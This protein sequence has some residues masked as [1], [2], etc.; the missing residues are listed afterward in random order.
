MK[1]TLLQPLL[2]PSRRAVS[3][4][5]YGTLSFLLIAARASAFSYPDFS[6]TA[7]LNLTGN[8]AQVGS[9]IRLT[10]AAQSQK[11]AAWYTQK[12]FVAGGFSTTFTFRITNLGNSGG[13]GISFAVQNG[14]T[15]ILGTEYGAE[16]NSVPIGLG[17]SLDTFPNPDIG[18]VSDNFVAITTNGSHY[19]VQRD[20]NGTLN[21]SD[22]NLHSV[23]V[24]FNGASMSVSIDSIS[25]LSNI[26]V[27]MSLATDIGGNAWVG[28]GA[29]TGNAFENQ[30][31]TSWTFAVPEPGSAALLLCGFGLFWSLRRRRQSAPP[32]VLHPMI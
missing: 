31:L 22:G 13:D 3:G 19:V 8:A 17:V 26:A 21:L 16:S 7:G 23:Q 18:E 29:R 12:Q 25:L 27:P 4:V 28:F 2:R 11:G 20:L 9:V 24:D 10:P 15:G 5:V 6:S 30:D 32:D 14:G 1:T